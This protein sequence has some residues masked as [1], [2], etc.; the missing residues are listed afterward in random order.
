MVERCLQMRCRDTES[1]HK[2]TKEGNG[3]LDWDWHIYTLL[4]IKEITNESLLYNRGD[5][6]HCSVVT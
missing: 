2:D 3:E 6:T 1:R 4:Y 5:S